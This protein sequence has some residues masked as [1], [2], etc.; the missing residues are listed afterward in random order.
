M[1]FVVLAIAT[2]FCMVLSEFIATR[3][4]RISPVQAT[5][6]NMVI[7][8]LIPFSKLNLIFAFDFVVNTIIK[9]LNPTQIGAPT[10]SIQFN[11]MLLMLVLLLVALSVGDDAGAGLLLVLV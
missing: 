10:I 11:V 7:S 6:S 9:M 3:K 1:P 4:K 5:N 8:N 2:V